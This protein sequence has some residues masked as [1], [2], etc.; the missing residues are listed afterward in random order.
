[1]NPFIVTG[2][3]DPAYFCDREEEAARLI[4]SLDNGNNLVIISPRRMGKTGLIQ[5][6]Y[7]KTGMEKN[8]L[9]FFH[10]HLTY[11]QSEGVYLY[12]G[13]RDL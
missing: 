9:H 12:A 4:R 7:E 6:C 11:F 2:K 3:I 1:M 10:R 13:E 5:F 8:V